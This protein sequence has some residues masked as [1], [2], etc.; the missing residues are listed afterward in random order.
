M[1]SAYIF[2]LLIALI[3]EIVSFTWLD[4]SSAASDNYTDFTS[5]WVAED[6]SEAVFSGISGS[7]AI[8]NTVPQI[9][10]D[11]TLYMC[12][13]SVNL[14]VSVGNEF[15]Y[16][17]KQYDKAFLGKTAGSFFAGIPIKKDD[18]GKDI[19]LHIDNP[20]NDGSGKVS[21]IYFGSG[22][23][24]LTAR[25]G[26][27]VPGYVV[28]V[29]IT[30]LGLLFIIM[31]I[32]M[33]HHDAV[34]IELLYF[35][36]FT[37][38]IGIFMLTDCKFLQLM[39]PHAHFYHLV[40]ETHMMLFVVPLFLFL[41]KMYDNCTEN[42][43]YCI[44]IMCGFN[45][46]ACYLF[47]MFGRKDYHETVWI[48]HLTYIVGIIFIFIIVI[49]GLIKNGR[50]NMYHNV[51]ICCICVAAVTDIILLNL[52][53][54]FETTLYTRFG[55]LVFICL[56][57]LQIFL[58]FFKRYREGMKAQLVSRLAYHDGL[59]DLLNRTSYMEDVQSLEKNMESDVIIAMFDVNDLKKINDNYGH[60]AGDNMIIAVAEEMKSCFGKL[61]KCYRI[62]GDEFVFISHADCTEDSF[63]K[64]SDAF[65]QNLKQAAATKKFMFPITVAMG[66][67]LA[68]RTCDNLNSVINDA[69]SKMYSNKK[70]MKLGTVV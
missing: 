38:N 57:G 6:G 50:N 53:N 68:N 58:G 55:V 60:I 34:G 14:K 64:A 35:A 49:G 25:V 18:V 29:L 42:M 36:L 17:S 33:W 15:V 19:V 26:A 40:A 9:Q 70:N 24:I 7:Y 22:I 69:D 2:F 67:S 1:F 28:S 12:L 61:G 62:G 20:Y 11:S 31:F 37:F 32:P 59:T 47:N 21:Q 45:F 46:I 41:H 63:T 51:G 54:S 5:G 56:E 44:S 66:Y 4:D 30:F 65:V 8:K 39:Y 43:V 52:G 27:I 23:D 48:T 10:Q 16:E 3:T 13:N